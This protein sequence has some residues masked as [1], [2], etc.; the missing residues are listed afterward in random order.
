MKKSTLHPA[1]GEKHKEY[2]RAAQDATISV[3]EGAVRAGKTIDNIAAFAF[4]IQRGTPDRIHLATG[5]TAANAKLNIG[6]ANGY[7]LE[8]IF[9]GRCRWTKYKGNEALVIRS[10]G[11]DYVVIFAGA[12]KADSFKKIRGNSYGMWIATEI[13]LHHKNTI[14]EAFNRQLAAKHRRILW[15]LNP[16]SPGEWIYTDYIDKFPEQFGDKYNY[17]HFTI[18]DNVNI[19]PERIAEI[20]SQYT[21]GSIWYRRDILGERC[22]AEGIVY[23]MFDNIVPTEPRDYDQYFI[24]MDYGILNPTS[25]HLYG[26]C[27]GTWYAVKE[28]YHSGRETQRQKTDEQYYEDLLQLAGDLPIH[29][30]IVDPSAASFITLVEQRHKFK[31]WSADNAV[32]E[33]IQHTAQCL[34]DKSILIN[35]CCKR[36]ITEFGLYRWDEESP[37]DKVVKENDHAMDDIRYFIQTAG[38]WRKNT[39]RRV[40]GIGV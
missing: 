26:R 17:Q 11:R 36:M 38:I 31:V 7:G 29:R 23:P 5:S 1:F 13:N 3:A 30:L 22:N 6:D 28:F 18:R 27:G 9:R 8:Y 15:D 10:H 4:N 24:S 39:G 19:T 37:E 20:E 35:D 34:S 33:G 25:M 32:L 14:R 21:P 12:A 40:P 2:I 16:S